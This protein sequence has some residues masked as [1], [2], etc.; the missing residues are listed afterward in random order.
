MNQILPRAKEMLDLHNASFVINEP[1][2][3]DSRFS[4]N[5]F[6]RNDSHSDTHEFVHDDIHS[7][8]ECF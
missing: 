8:T 3:D 5:E 6:V 1:L 7:N 2:R 4:A